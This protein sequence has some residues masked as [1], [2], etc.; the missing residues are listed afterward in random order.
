[1]CGITICVTMIVSCTL[2]LAALRQVLKLQPQRTSTRLSGAGGHDVSLSGAQ[3]KRYE[4]HRSRVNDLSFDERAE[5]V[6]SCSDDGSVVVRAL[7]LQRFKMPCMHALVYTKGRC[8]SRL[9]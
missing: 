2:H 9:H 7:L 6:A 3:V 8:C 5:H 4:A 1:M